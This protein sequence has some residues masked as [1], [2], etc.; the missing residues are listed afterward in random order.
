MRTNICALLAACALWASAC[1][2]SNSAN[3]E[4]AKN[5]A[6][7]NAAPSSP[8]ASPSDSPVV[9]NEGT[10]GALPSDVVRVSAPPVEVRAGGRAEAS[11]RLDIT[12]PYH[13]NANP[14]SQSFLIPT[15][16]TLAPEPGVKP[17]K[18]AYPAAL[19]KKFAFAEQPLAVYEGS[20]EIK[21]PLSVEA[22]A[23]KGERT[24]RAKVRVQPCDDN[25]CYPPRNVETTISLNVR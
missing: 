22:S 11:V 14:P 13:V 10:G 25:A 21:L 19:N 18:P 2:G 4:T 15:E 3:P 20:A 7:P 1:G 6:R 5:A 24:L 17:G 8:A 23:A 9:V 12:P 16:L